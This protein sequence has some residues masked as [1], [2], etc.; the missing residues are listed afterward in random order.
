[1]A[2]KHN[3]TKKSSTLR[4][5]DLFCGAGGIT[6]GFREAGYVSLYGNDVMPEAIETF[7]LNHPGAIA[8]CRPIEDVDPAAWRTGCAGWWAAVPGVFD[9]RAGAFF[10]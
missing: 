5:I 9:Q 4:T 8:D 6:E 2:A 3:M 7:K 1:M 10:R